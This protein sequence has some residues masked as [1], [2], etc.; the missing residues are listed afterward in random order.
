MIHVFGSSKTLALRI[1]LAAAAAGVLSLQQRSPWPTRGPGTGRAAP[2]APGAA[3]ASFAE[4]A[5]R[6][7][8]LELEPTV[9][10]APQFEASRAEILA[11]ARAEPVLFLEA[12]VQTDSSPDVVALRERLFHEAQPWRAL[13]DIMARYRR[14]PR[15]LR[16]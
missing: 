7:R 4:C 6:R 10:G 8:T 12:P 11:R 9:P 3:F 15:E 16:R 5:R 1:C 2:Q 13:S 14:T